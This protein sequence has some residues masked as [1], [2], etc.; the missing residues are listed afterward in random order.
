MTL[1]TQTD[2]RSHDIARGSN[3]NVARSQWLS[4]E[5]ECRLAVL[6]A[7]GDREAR[8][9]L[10]QANLGLVY[11]IARD[12]LG[13]GMEFDDLI[14]EGNLGLIRGAEGFDPRF[15]TRFGTYACYWIK[16]SIRHALITTTSTIRLPARM[17]RLLTKWRR[18]ELSLYRESGRDPNFDEIASLL[19][20]SESQKTTMAKAHRA[21]RVTLGG[22][23]TGEARHW[24]PDG[25]IRRTTPDATLEADEQRDI[26]LRWMDCLKA[27]ERATL[28]LLYGLEG[29]GPLTLQAIGR[30]LGVTRQ[31][32]R[33]LHARALRKLREK[34]VDTC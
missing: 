10:V 34:Q 26:L 30:R 4:R 3:R 6:I 25:A 19:R 8:N 12:Y 16:E 5:E 32:V 2:R 22:P 21:R 15:G 24:S 11:R 1:M 29:E 17:V 27:R 28:E 31:W 7:D 14:G 23:A 33:K 13:R 9:L 20:L 18:A